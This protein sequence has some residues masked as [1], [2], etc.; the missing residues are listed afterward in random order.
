MRGS[1]SNNPAPIHQI[2]GH[3]IVGGKLI[4]LK[5]NL[6]GCFRESVHD[7]QKLDDRGKVRIEWVLVL[8]R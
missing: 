5:T 6:P 4:Y 7:A 8:G 2:Q 1:F 3:I